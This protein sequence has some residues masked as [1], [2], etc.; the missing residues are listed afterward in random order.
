M[1]ICDP[2][3]KRSTS[4]AD[5]IWIK[6][7]DGKN[8]KL[9]ESPD[10]PL[11]GYRS[12]SHWSEHLCAVGMGKHWQYGQCDSQYQYNAIYDANDFL[13]GAIGVV[14]FEK[15]FT[16]A[17]Q[18]IETT[19]AVTILGWILNE[20]NFD[21]CFDLSRPRMLIH[22]Y[23]RKPEIEYQS[24]A[25]P[26]VKSERN[27]QELRCLFC[28]KSMGSLLED[29]CGGPEPSKEC[30]CAMD[31]LARQEGSCYDQGCL[32]T[33]SCDVFEMENCTNGSKMIQP[34]LNLSLIFSFLKVAS[35]ALLM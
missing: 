10:F 33:S 26:I 35:E 22:V 18:L 34:A 30:C 2:Q 6:L 16:D 8:F 28:W 12:D 9:P 5:G 23:L 31:H 32:M 29:K 17:P 4:V 27:N 11:V 20:T 15:T 19:L 25:T 13:I 7:P 24:C 14:N 3:S 21:P 1:T